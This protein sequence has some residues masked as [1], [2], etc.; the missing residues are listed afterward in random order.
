MVSTRVQG[1]QG[2][3]Q[4]YGDQNYDDDDDDEEEEEDED[5]EMA[6]SGNQGDN[7]GSD[8]DGNRQDGGNSAT[9]ANNNDGA[10]VEADEEAQV[11]QPRRNDTN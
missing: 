1:S 5:E 7:Y 11:I 10:N 4:Q 3:A 9:V 2:V 6:H 8:G